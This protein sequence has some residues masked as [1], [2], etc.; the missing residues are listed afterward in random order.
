MGHNKQK[1]NL[2]THRLKMLLAKRR[3]RVLEHVNNA[4]NKE[5]QLLEC[6]VE[7]FQIENKQLLEEKEKHLQFMD[8]FRFTLQ[9]SVREKKTLEERLQGL[10]DGSR[11]ITNGKVE[12]L[13]EAMQLIV[14]KT[15]F[16]TMKPLKQ[17]NEVN[18]IACKVLWRVRS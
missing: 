5:V 17:I 13:L 7:M 1:I 2:A 11:E 10:A 4:L 12:E 18:E 14:D 6:S 8:E 15:S 3:I 16:H 9:A